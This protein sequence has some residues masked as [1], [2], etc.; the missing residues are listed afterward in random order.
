MAKRLANLRAQIQWVFEEYRLG[1]LLGLLLFLVAIWLSAAVV[2]WVSERSPSRVPPLGPGDKFYA[3]RDCLWCSTVYL[4]SGLEDFNPVTLPSKIAAVVVMVVG[5]GV[6]GLTGAQLLATFVER[7]RLR[8]ILRRKPSC[9]FSGHIVVCG[10]SER[11]PAVLEELRTQPAGLRRQVVVVAPQALAI[12]IA[13]RRVRRGVW[14]VPGDPVRDEV[15]RR[16]D[17]G[18]AHSVVVLPPASAA[19]PEVDRRGADA[20]SILVSLAVAA[21]NP[22]VE[23]CVELADRRSARRFRPGPG[24]ELLNV[25]DVA[26]KLIAHAAQ[27]HQLGD[28]FHRLLSAAPAAGTVWIVP[29]PDRLVGLTFRQ[30]RK[31]MI[32]NDREAHVLLGLRR[33]ASPPDPPRL[34]I[35][36]GTEDPRIGTGESLDADVALVPGDQLVVL[37]RQQPDL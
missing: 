6:L 36:P 18:T 33:A 19:G 8:N 35:N 10:W 26:G 34:V 13:D 32:D 27:K 20:R 21:V 24:L 1:R 29:V 4:V 12:E 15:L 9:T 17:A 16:A 3:F 2:I 11:A 14:A 22:G 31:D 5:V 23:V 30:V 37:A 28:L 25:R 7:R